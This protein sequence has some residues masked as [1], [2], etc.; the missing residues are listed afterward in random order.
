MDKSPLETGGFS[1]G[2]I[3]KVPPKV[4]ETE[5]RAACCTGLS[6]FGVLVDTSYLTVTGQ[7]IRR[8]SPDSE[9]RAK[10][11]RTCDPLLPNV[12]T[13]LSLSN[14]SGNFS[15]SNKPTIADFKIKHMAVVAKVCAT[16]VAL[17]NGVVGFC[18]AAD[19]FRDLT[20]QNRFAR[21]SDACLFLLQYVTDV[22]LFRG[23]TQVCENRFCRQD[24]PSSILF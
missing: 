19:Y 24:L 12:T 14:R 7:V 13:W 9:P 11:V 6:R 3:A 5:G 18:H 2:R 17:W 4:I 8:K 23:K 22:N 20:R 10:Q 15:A 21:K 1:F 16:F